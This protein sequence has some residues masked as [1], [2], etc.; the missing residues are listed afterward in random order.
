M[1]GNSMVLAVVLELHTHKNGTVSDTQCK[2]AQAFESSS[3]AYLLW[4]YRR[5]EEILDSATVE[6]SDQWAKGAVG[7]CAV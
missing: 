4:R 1:V 7:Q 6:T 5:T 2:T 3:V